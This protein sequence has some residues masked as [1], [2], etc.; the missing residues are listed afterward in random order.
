[1]SGVER[2]QDLS[3]GAQPVAK[4]DVV[5]WTWDQ[6]GFTHYSGVSGAMDACDEETIA[7]VEKSSLHSASHSLR[8]WCMTC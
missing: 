6:A 4:D 7:A 5:A 2:L 8:L 1:M 3:G